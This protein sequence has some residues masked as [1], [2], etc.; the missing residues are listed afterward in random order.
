M[1]P[2]QLR[3]IQTPLKEKYRSDGDSAVATL[4]ASGTVDFDAIAVRLIKEEGCPSIPGLHPMAGGDGSYSCAAEMLLEALVGCA[5]VTLAAVCTAM[6][7]PVE[8]AKLVAEG[9]MDFRG[10]LGIDRE[11][12]VGFT[13]IRL[14]FE[15]ES[16]AED[17]KLAKAVQLAER[18]CVVAQSLKNIEATWT[19]GDGLGVG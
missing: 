19:R 11:T 4:S 9:D 2:E 13:A 18:Y 10:T 5:G 12:A 17:E 3:E 7:I 6:A 8:S 1:T 16:P 14:R 15:F